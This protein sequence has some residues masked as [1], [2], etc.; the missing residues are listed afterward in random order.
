MSVLPAKVNKMM[1]DK[2]VCPTVI[3]EIT[4][5]WRAYE[6]NTSGT[7]IPVCHLMR[8]LK[9]NRRHLPHWEIEGSIYYI[10]FR[11]L[12]GNLSPDEI[13]IVL[14]HIKDGNQ[15]F[16]KLYAIVVMPDHVHFIIKPVEG[17]SPSRI[18]KGIKGVSAKLINTRR[19][20]I[21]SVWL[22]ESYDRI[23]RNEKEFLE[24]V[25]YMYLNPMKSGLVKDGEEY[26]GWY[27]GE[28]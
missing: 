5:N 19:G 26:Y 23:I 16:Y 12:S 2:N 28:W 27:M 24:K 8:K 21:G 11:L 20:A 7:D 18:M 22:D 9:I 3:F 1:T 10:T 13:R 17:Y 6:D 4:I 14:N 25:N 15:K